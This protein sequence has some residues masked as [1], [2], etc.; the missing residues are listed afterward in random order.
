VGQNS[1]KLEG[2][3]CCAV[4]LRASLEF[5]VNWNVDKKMGVEEATLFVLRRHD[6]KQGW[7]P[8]WFVKLCLRL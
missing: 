3:I 7:L 1:K 6:A 5:F 4:L 8:N 2:S